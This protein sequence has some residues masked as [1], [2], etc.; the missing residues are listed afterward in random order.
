M[1]R[2]LIPMFAAVLALT[3][4]DGSGGGGALRIEPLPA[5]VAAPCDRPEDYLIVRD[6]EILAGRIGD[7]LSECGAEKQ[8]AVDGYEGV[9]AALGKGEAP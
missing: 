7:A 3:A 1:K 8:I 9:R 5:E 2:A 4:C 6:W